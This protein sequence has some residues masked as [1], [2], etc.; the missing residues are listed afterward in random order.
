MPL[1]QSAGMGALHV[2]EDKNWKEINA[3]KTRDSNAELREQP[4]NGT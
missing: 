3:L 4:L 1:Y 2:S